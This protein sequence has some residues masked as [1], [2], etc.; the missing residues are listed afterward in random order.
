MSVK[1]PINVGG[2]VKSLAEDVL[3]GDVELKVLEDVAT[4]HNDILQVNQMKTCINTS[5]TA[6]C[7]HEK[8]GKNSLFSD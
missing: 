4:Q 2:E 7:I 3:S 1:I 5:H 6:K 8:R